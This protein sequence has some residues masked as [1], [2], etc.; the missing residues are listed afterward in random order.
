MTKPLSKLLVICHITAI[1]LAC[2]DQAP[3]TAEIFERY[4]AAS[5]AHDLETLERMTADDIVWQLGPWTLVGKEE[6]LRPHYADLVNHTVL[7]AREVVVRGDTVECTLVERSDATRAYGPDS[8]ITHARY[9]FEEGLVVKKEPWAPSPS[10]MELN[11]RS[12]PFRRWVRE[13]HPEAL[14]VIVDSTGT[15]RW[16]RSAVDIVHEL[17]EAWVATGKPGS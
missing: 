6:A 3:S 16:T 4:I 11:G 17:R 15:P 5:N 10:L 13:Q 2:S 9:V 12:E 7:E 8:L 14:A 1:G